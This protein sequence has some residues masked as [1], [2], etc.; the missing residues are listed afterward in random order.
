ML[1][2]IVA[3][4]LPSILHVLSVSSVTDVSSQGHVA[5]F[6]IFLL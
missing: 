2:E 4:I 1:K 3:M 6:L 5:R